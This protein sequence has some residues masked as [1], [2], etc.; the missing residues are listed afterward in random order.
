MT[1]PTS[2]DSAGV[3]ARTLD[4]LHLVGEVVRS[5]GLAVNYFR[6]S[7]WIGR[8][9]DGRFRRGRLVRASSRDYSGASIQNQ[10]QLSCAHCFFRTV[11]VNVLAK[12]RGKLAARTRNGSY[13]PAASPSDAG[14]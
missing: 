5:Y 4:G 6:K 10:P 7:C 1:A 11:R 9:A 8:L 2:C 3:A 14:N 13:A 12:G